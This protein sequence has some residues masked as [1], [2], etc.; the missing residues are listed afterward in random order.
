MNGWHRLGK[1]YTINMIF[2]VSAVLSNEQHEFCK[3]IATK[4]IVV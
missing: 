4:V 2:W 1:K 3:K